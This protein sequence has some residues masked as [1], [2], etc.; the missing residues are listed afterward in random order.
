MTGITTARTLRRPGGDSLTALQVIALLKTRL[1]REISI[2]TFYDAP[3]VGLLARA[4]GDGKQEEG[5]GAL[6]GV[7]ERA[8]TRLEMMQRRRQKRGGQPALGPSR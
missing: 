7:E 5:P 4:L 6:G 8:G 2:V 3:T 1:N